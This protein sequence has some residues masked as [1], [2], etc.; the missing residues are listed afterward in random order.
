MTS[1]ALTQ[2]VQRSLNLKLTCSHWLLVI[3]YLPLFWLREGIAPENFRNHG[4]KFLFDSFGSL[5]VEAEGTKQSQNWGKDQR[6]QVR[7]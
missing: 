3:L 6:V 4:P 2:L 7:G 5:G 1:G